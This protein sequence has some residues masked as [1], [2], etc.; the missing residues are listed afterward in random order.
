[1]NSLHAHVTGLEVIVFVTVFTLSVAAVL[2]AGE[3]SRRAGETLEKGRKPNSM[4]IF[5]VA[6]FVLLVAAILLAGERPPRAGDLLEKAGIPGVGRDLGERNRVGDLISERLNT[7]G[8]YLVPEE[9][10]RR[11]GPPPKRSEEPPSVPFPQ[12]ILSYK[13]REGEV[14]FR[15]ELQKDPIEA[16]RLWSVQFDPVAR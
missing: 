1:M 12:C 14:T 13:V 10:E 15:F 5:F 7:S 4:A 8:I 9:L 11:L 16:W 6:V 3:Q 2:L